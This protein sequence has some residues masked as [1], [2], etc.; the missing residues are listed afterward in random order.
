MRRYGLAAS[1]Q[2]LVRAIVTSG[3]PWRTFWWMESV[4]QGAED[5]NA[6]G[7]PSQLMPGYTGDPVGSPSTRLT[8][9]KR[10]FKP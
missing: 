1:E 8:A 9:E 7:S 10:F 6:L 2:L 5:L 3:F 4:F